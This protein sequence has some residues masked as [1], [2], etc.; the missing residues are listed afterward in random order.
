MKTQ[1][2]SGCRLDKMKKSSTVRRKPR[3]RCRNLRKY[4]ANTKR[5]C[6]GPYGRALE[7]YV[8]YFLCEDMFD[9]ETYTMF[10]SDSTCTRY[11][12]T[13]KKNNVKRQSMAD[14][15][16][17]AITYDLTYK[18]ADAKE[19]LHGLNFGGLV[20]YIVRGEKLVDWCKIENTFQEQTA[21]V[22]VDATQETFHERLESFKRVHLID[23]YTKKPPLP[24]SSEPRGFKD[25]KWKEMP[26]EKQ[27][28]ADG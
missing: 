21:R 2:M 15:V 23:A 8:D 26:G 25:G 11:H 6:A 13:N 28:I 3:K 4:A 9:E 17:A 24:K 22:L 7:D 12:P 27:I 10:F 16:I 20:D 1:D 19:Q 18:R 5:F 14:G